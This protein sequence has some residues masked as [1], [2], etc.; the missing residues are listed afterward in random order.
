MAGN[1]PRR[2]DF[3]HQALVGFFLPEADQH[4]LH[5]S[6]FG[7]PLE[8]TYFYG[9][10]HTDDGAEYAFIR[11]AITYTTRDISIMAADGTGL[12]V[13]PSSIQGAR[14]C[15]VE[16]ELFEGRES[17]VG[18]SSRGANFQVRLGDGD[19]TWREQGAGE[20][21]LDIGG[22]LAAPG[23]QVFVPWRTKAGEGGEPGAVGACFYT[24]TP[25]LAEGTMLGKRVTGF[26]AVDHSY[27]PNGVGWNN[28]AI[29]MR[30]QG[31][32]NVFA[33]E[34]E[35]GSI[36]WGHMSIGADRFRFV[37]VSS[38]DSVLVNSASVNAEITWRDDE[39]VD[40]ITFDVGDGQPWEFVT[41]LN[42]KMVDFSAA[43]PGWS[44]HTG[45]IRRVGETRV[46]KRHWAWQEVFPERVR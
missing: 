43:R 31:G 14:G 40:R 23:F 11:K 39:F 18:G 36:E 46:L 19:F 6:Y 7:L 10:M 8:G 5:Q 29:W 20:C 27:L 17:F 37:A 22:T 35:D 3:E 42:G 21:L 28:S 32:W 15:K 25:Y 38:A 2:G 30:L 41:D 44:G 13:H 34:Y 45:V 24:S 26:F 9:V 33:N 1:F 16:R 12:R 4:L